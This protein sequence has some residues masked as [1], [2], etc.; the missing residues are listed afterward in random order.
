VVFF[1]T[2]ANSDWNALPQKPAYIALIHELIANSVDMGDGWMNLECGQ[3]VKLPLGLGISG[4][5][6]LLDPAMK[7]VPIDPMTEEGRTTYVSK[8][9]D[10]PGL[11]KL[12]T[13]SKTI[14]IAVNIAAEESDVRTIPATAIVKAMGIEVQI[15]GA[16][17][18]DVASL[19]LDEN[20][21]FGWSL[22]MAVLGLISVEC[23]MA[24]R[25][26]HYRK[27]VVKHG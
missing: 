4:T 18:R 7:P 2:T 10:K 19:S 9:L 17:S 27:T 5:P 23:L 16:E 24:M 13:G 15:L 3:S 6:S 22:M 21:D 12:N 11:Y 20:A 25:F 1:S 8:A 14:P 26:G